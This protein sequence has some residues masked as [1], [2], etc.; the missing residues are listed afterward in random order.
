MKN[1]IFRTG[2][3]AYSCVAENESGMAEGKATIVI[4]EYIT[5]IGKARVTIPKLSAG[6]FLPRVSVL[7]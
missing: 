4:T 6:T 5:Y 3:G 1:V 2:S 7:N